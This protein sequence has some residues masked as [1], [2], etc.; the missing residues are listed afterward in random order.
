MEVPDPSN[1]QFSEKT[2][3]GFLL[4]NVDPNAKSEDIQELN[5]FLVARVDAFWDVVMV[6]LRK[7]ENFNG[8][9]LNWYFEIYKEGV[10]AYKVKE[11][12]FTF[13]R[14]SQEEIA[15]IVKFYDGKILL[16][17]VDLG[18]SFLSNTYT[19][20]TSWIRDEMIMMRLEHIY[21]SSDPYDWIVRA[22]KEEYGVMMQKPTS[23]PGL[24]DVI[25]NIGLIMSRRV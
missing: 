12:P 15:E 21:S 22:E 18:V 5:K 2:L 11:N 25:N 20:L 10:E 24:V 19:L 16:E 9:K 3:K 4:K 7:A 6:P 17:Y 13:L 14:I 23:I 8:N 1:Q